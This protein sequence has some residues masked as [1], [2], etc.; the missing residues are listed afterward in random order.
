MKNLEIQ[1]KKAQQ[2]SGTFLIFTFLLLIFVVVGYIAEPIKPP[3]QEVLPWLPIN[4]G[5]YGI[6]GINL[7]FAIILAILAI[8]LLISCICS[9]G[10][11]GGFLV[12]V[13]VYGVLASGLFWIFQKTENILYVEFMFSIL[14]VNIVSTQPVPG[15]SETLGVALISSL[16]FT[17]PFLFCTTSTLYYIHKCIRLKGPATTERILR[18]EAERAA[19]REPFQAEN[20]QTASHDEQHDHYDYSQTHHTYAEAPNYFRG[21]QTLADLEHRHKCLMHA[22]HPDHNWGNEE[23]A[24]IINDQYNLAKEPFIS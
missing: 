23:I 16:L 3:I 14:N 4:F 9:M 13:L 18:E 5:A 22:Y 20:Q 2:R 24:K 10:I 11:I 8:V 1:Y 19:A 7:S 6:V 21:C 12:F 17:V 15:F